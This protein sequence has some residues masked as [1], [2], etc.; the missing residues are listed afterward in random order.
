MCEYFRKNLKKYL[1]FWSCPYTRVSDPYT[2]VFWPI[3]CVPTRVFWPIHCSYQSF[4]THTLF[5]PEF[6]DP[7]TLYTVPI[8]EFSDPYTPVFRPIHCVPTRVFWPIYC[9]YQSESFL[10]IHCFHHLTI[11]FVPTRVFW[12]IR[13]VPTLC[14]LFL[15]E[16][17]GP[18]TVPTRVLWHTHC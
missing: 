8:L 1:Q 15:P 12:H 3:H 17:S 10:N 6:F 11:H 5:L 2:P 7:Y 16:F 4:L 13:F 9:S 14:T 18:Y